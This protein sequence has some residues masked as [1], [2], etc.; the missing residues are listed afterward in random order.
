[1]KRDAP[2]VGSHDLWLPTLDP[3]IRVGGI[4]VVQLPHPTSGDTQAVR[5]SYEDVVVLDLPAADDLGDLTLGLIRE[6][7]VAGLVV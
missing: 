1:M 2:G 7:D 5:D 3:G 6:I 4:G